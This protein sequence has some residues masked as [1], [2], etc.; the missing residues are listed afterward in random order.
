MAINLVCIKMAYKYAQKALELNDNL[1]T[2]H[3][4]IGS[5]TFS[6]TSMKRQSLKRSGLSPSIP[7][8]LAIILVWLGWSAP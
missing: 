4:L 8:E 1:D 7:M 6:R 2:A 3:L 5:V